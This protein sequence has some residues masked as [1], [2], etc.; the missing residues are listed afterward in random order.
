MD[1]ES[2]NEF[3]KIFA[4]IDVKDFDKKVPLSAVF[5]PAKLFINLLTRRDNECVI[6]YNDTAPTPSEIRLLKII[7]DYAKSIQKIFE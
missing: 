2:R 4:K 1:Q 6:S 3:N 5:E 7:I